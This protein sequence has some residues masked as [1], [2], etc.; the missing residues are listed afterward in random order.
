MQLV[1]RELR[2]GDVLLGQRVH[3]NGWH[4]VRVVARD[5]LK[6]DNVRLRVVGDVVLETL[7]RCAF[8]EVRLGVIAAAGWKEEEKEDGNGGFGSKPGASIHAI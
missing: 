6:T 4:R 1:S 8:G 2:H 7:V 5:A 3:R